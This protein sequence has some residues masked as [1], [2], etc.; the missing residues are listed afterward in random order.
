[1]TGLSRTGWSPKL[2]KSYSDRLQSQAPRL[3]SLDRVSVSASSL[4]VQ[5]DPLCSDLP[6]S[7]LPVT[8]PWADL[9][10]L[11][12]RSS[13]SEATAKAL[14][15]PSLLATVLAVGSENA[16]FEI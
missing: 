16:V 7:R 4:L 12:A 6:R 11:R 8:K 9:M 1:M 14:S 13:R 5:L 3:L 15:L 10:S 2:V